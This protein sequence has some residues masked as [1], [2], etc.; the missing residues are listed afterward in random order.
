MSAEVDA[1]LDR[2]VGLD[3]YTRDTA[4]QQKVIKHFKLSLER[5]V[6]LARRA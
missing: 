6:S 2:S 3:G 5:M 4:L 1:I